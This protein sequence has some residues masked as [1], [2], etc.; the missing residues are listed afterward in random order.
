M[1]NLLSLIAIALVSVSVSAAPATKP[2][3]TVNKQTVAAKKQP[4]KS[5]V[6]P[7]VKKPNQV[8][9]KAV[10]KKRKK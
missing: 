2:V 6:R 10:I 5:K 1:R 9:N 7:A 4:P 8:T 3:K